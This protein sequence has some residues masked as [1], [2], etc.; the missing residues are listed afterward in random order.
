VK[1]VRTEVLYEMFMAG[2]HIDNLARSYELD[3]SLEEA[4]IRF[5]SVKPEPSAM[6]FPEP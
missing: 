6:T 4:A 5:E 1:G 3:R 2:D